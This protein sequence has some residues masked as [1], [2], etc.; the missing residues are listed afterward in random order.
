MR[1]AIA[2]S[3][4]LQESLA[5]PH[6]RRAIPLPYRQEADGP[7]YLHSVPTPGSEGGQV[8]PNPRLVIFSVD[9]PPVHVFRIVGVRPLVDSGGLSVDSRPPLHYLEVSVGMF[10]GG[11]LCLAAT[12][13]SICS[14]EKGYGGGLVRGTIVVKINK[15]GQPEFCGWGPVAPSKKREREKENE[16]QLSRPPR[17]V[18]QGLHIHAP[19]PV[20]S[21]SPSSMRRSATRS[22]V[23]HPRG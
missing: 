13:R 11:W 22:S 7:C 17:A 14:I 5:G 9:G 8:I 20:V 1:N 3:D 10:S 6:L 15:D 18:E 23:D 21:L 2:V 16:D 19:V 4:A 12:M